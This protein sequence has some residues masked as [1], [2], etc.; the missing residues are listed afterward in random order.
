MFLVPFYA[1]YGREEWRGIHKVNTLNIIV[2]CDKSPVLRGNRK[3]RMCCKEKLNIT[4]T[5]QL[6]NVET[7]N[8]KYD[9]P[10]NTGYFLPIYLAT[11]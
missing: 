2:N 7:F 1:S 8:Y 3:A 4:T 6:K 9:E 11:F 10:S 5:K